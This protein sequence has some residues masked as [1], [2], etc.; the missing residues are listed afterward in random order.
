MRMVSRPNRATLVHGDRSTPTDE[1]VGV[2]RR[3]GQPGIASRCSPGKNRA[4]SSH[5]ELPSHL[6]GLGSMI[7]AVSMPVPKPCA[8]GNETL[9]PLQ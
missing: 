2:S 3:V 5:C 9:S 8:W 1:P 6:P 4:A 7:T